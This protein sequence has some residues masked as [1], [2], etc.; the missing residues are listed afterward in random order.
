MTRVTLEREGY[1]WSVCRDAERVWGPGSETAAE[2]AHDRINRQLRRKRRPCI[3]CGAPFMSE[4]A[5][6]RMCKTC[7][8]H[9]SDI[10]QGAV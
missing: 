9:A 1:G 3:T 5:H 2:L 7:R 8:T 4:G 6:N 10:C